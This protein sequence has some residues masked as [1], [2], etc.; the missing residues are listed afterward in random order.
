MRHLT[1]GRSR[2][3]LTRR[4]SSYFVRS[5]AI[6]AAGV[7]IVTLLLPLAVGYTCAEQQISAL[8]AEA[9]AASGTVHPKLNGL[10]A[11][12]PPAGVVGAEPSIT[13]CAGQKHAQA[14]PDLRSANRS[15]AAEDIGTGLRGEYY[16]S[17][18]FTNPA[19]TRVDPTLNFDWGSGAPDTALDRDTFSVRWTGQVQARY[20]E[21]YTFYTKS[22]DGVRLWVNGQIVIDNWTNHSLVENQG[23]IN[24]VAD[25]RYDIRVDYYEQSGNAVLQL[26]WSNPS[27]VKEA[28][29][30][31]QLYPSASNTAPPLGDPDSDATLD[32]MTSELSPA[33]MI[34]TTRPQIALFANLSQWGSEAPR[35]IA[36][37]TADGVRDFH[38]ASLESSIAL[39]V[40]QMTEP[41][42]LLWFRGANGWSEWDSPWLV[43]W[44]KRPTSATLDQDG[45]H[46]AAQLPLEYV[47]MMPL[48]GLFKPDTSGWAAPPAEA[49]TQARFWA[50][51]L[52]SY[53]LKSDETY[54]VDATS[55]AIVVRNQFQW[56]LTSDDWNT[57]PSKLAP[58]SPTLAL[59]YQSQRMPMTLS[60]PVYDP[61]VFTAFGPYVGVLDRDSYDVAFDV[62]KYITETE[63][64]QSPDANNPVV[65]AA[66]ARLQSAMQST[67]SS[68]DG[69]FHQDFGDPPG[70]ASPPPQTLEGGNSAWAFMSAQYYLRA[71]PYLSP[72]LQAQAKPRLQR[73]F[74]DWVLQPNRYR[75]YQGKLLLYGPGIGTWGGYDDAGKFSSNTIQTL[76]T[77]AHYTGDWPLIKERWPLI[78]QLFVTPRES[79]WRGFGRGNIAEMGDEAA[80]ALAIARLAYFV[81]DQDTYGYAAYI[82]A[83]ELVHHVVK[84]TGANYFVSRQPIF[85]MTRMPP[86][87]YPTNIMGDMSGWQLDGPSSPSNTGEY[88]YLN[89][90]VRFGDTDVARF[91]RDYLQDLERTELDGLLAS[92]RFTSGRQG[93]FD[94]PHILPS[95]VRIESLLLN[96]SPDQLAQI[97]PVDAPVWP[98]SGVA[99][100]TTAFLRTSRPTSYA[101]LIPADRASTDW[102]L[103]IERDRLDSEPFMSTNVQ[104]SIGASLAATVQWSSSAPPA[105]T[106]FGWSP[107]VSNRGIPGGTRWSFGQILTDQPVASATTSRISWNTELV[108]LSSARK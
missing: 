17:L 30:Q 50:H 39:P 82:F 51:A 104:R 29:P 10:Q 61:N 23:T 58:L 25:Q 38:R 84:H 15:Q 81:G 100:Y 18:D 55:G 80:P 64:E 69:L 99:A 16:D 98:N 45:L 66:L 57:T 47:A 73:Y 31:R 97:S 95:L 42:M 54:R 102:A 90:W 20:S 63:Q 101:T 85:S 75:P 14:I 72:Q 70:F 59:A 32:I 74:A 56:L 77:Y 71:L 7:L 5:F 6:V 46:A 105:V 12:Q 86:E 89:R 108:A 49:V 53:P 21:N 60:A 34:H 93:S 35:H 33:V 41:W 27:Q 48:Y 3:V 106:W 40:D 88:Q 4:S 24:L 36:L 67:F 94:D 68:A 1:N 19:F 78:K 22:D 9:L 76:W 11:V 26:M 91:H 62:L 13:D 8:P 83:R 92:G 79:S 96:K 44:Q 65:A 37:Q 52:R 107:K 2:S 103:G 87:V 28:I 43:V